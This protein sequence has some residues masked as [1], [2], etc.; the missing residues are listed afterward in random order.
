MDNNL[1]YDINVINTNVKYQWL[2]M[3][4]YCVCF[5]KHH[6]VYAA[7]HWKPSHDYQYQTRE[8]NV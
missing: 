8:Q 2:Y 5:I 1:H 6:D 4:V 7:R 3:W